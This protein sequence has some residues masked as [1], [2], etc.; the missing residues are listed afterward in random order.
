MTWGRVMNI[1]FFSLMDIESLDQS[2]I[3]ADLI[4]KFV[5]EGNKV[6]VISPIQ[7][8]KKRKERIITSDNYRI[9]KPIIGNVTNTPFFEKG[10]AI[11]TMQSVIINCIKKHL[12]NESMDL[13][14]VTTPPVSNVFLINY[15]K[16]KYNAKVYLLLKD[17]WPGS[18]SDLKLS[19]GK[20]VK[21][22]V[23]KLFGLLENLLY[24]SCDWIGCMS[25]ANVEYVI[26]NNPNVDNRKI[27]I[28]PNSIDSHDITPLS[29]SEKEQ[30]RK[31]YG[32]PLE[33]KCLIYGGTLGVGQ[34]VSFIV[35]C[36]KACEDLDCF[37]VISGWGVQYNILEDFYINS[38]PSN[39]LLI[40]GL[41]KED[42]EKL[43]QACDIGLVFLR[44][45]AK[46]PNFPSRVLTYMDYSLPILS[47]T[48]TVSDLNTL[49]S[50]NRIGW[51]CF[52]DNAQ[53]F[54][55]CVEEALSDN[56]EEIG[57]NGKKC[58]K[59]KFCARD[60]Y[61]IILNCYNNTL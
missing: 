2:N 60:S 11:F 40:N 41:P 43:M 5:D 8:R 17:I 58:L 46:T 45:T 57:K 26:K 34:N 18:L 61:N 51:T 36:I 42:Y 1:V 10:I 47:C 4:R 32:I 28:N 38:K 25:D 56:I 29:N 50:R 21:F 7:K 30:I 13:F 22:A 55:K 16:K 31:K 52:S 59:E 54:K 20:V 12:K 37:F 23:T 53:N 6:T 49:I 9:L 44:Y 33:K 35:N 19:G 14:I 15:V 48:D 27:H 24:K 39:L 3:Y